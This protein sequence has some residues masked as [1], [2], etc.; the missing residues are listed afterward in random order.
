MLE[1]FG[2]TYMALERLKSAIGKRVK[3]CGRHFWFN[4]G[5]EAS[6]N[7]LIEVYQI[8]KQKYGKWNEEMYLLDN[9]LEYY[10]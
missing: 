10:E 7:A 9:D 3:K 6:Q 2:K 8:N 1:H 5:I 4:A